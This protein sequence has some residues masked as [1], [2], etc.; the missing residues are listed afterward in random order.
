MNELAIKLREAAMVLENDGDFYRKYTTQA[1][2][3]RPLQRKHVNPLD[4]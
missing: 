3:A 2:P 1:R 4:T